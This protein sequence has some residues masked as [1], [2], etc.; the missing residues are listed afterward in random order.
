MTK[1]IVPALPAEDLRQALV[2]EK[3]KWALACKASEAPV[4]RFVRQ[5]NI[6]KYKQLLETA[7]DEAERQRISKILAEEEQK[8]K[9]AGD[10]IQYR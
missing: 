10:P 9:D 3:P 2:T 8:Q 6:A 4:D 5:Q 1:P 7:L